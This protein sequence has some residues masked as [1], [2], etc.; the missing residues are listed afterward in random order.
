MKAFLRYPTLYL[1]CLFALLAKSPAKGQHVALTS[2]ETAFHLRNHN[3]A[4]LTF[5]NS[6]AGFQSLIVKSKEGRFAEL[7]VRGYGKMTEEGR[8]AL[9]VLKKLIEMPVGAKAEIR[10]TNLEVQTIKLSDYK[11]NLP[12]MPAQPPVSKQEDDPS[13]LPFHIDRALYAND[14]FYGKEPVRVIPLGELRGTGI[15][16]LEI[17]PF[18]Y[19]PI[20]GELRVITSIRCEIV[21]RKASAGP[22][23]DPELF[24]PW[25]ES[26]FGIL[27]NHETLSRELIT[28]MPATYIIVSHPSF[29]DAL[30]P[31]IEW[32]T[33]KGFRIVEAYTDDP[34][35]G[36]TTYSIKA[37]LQDFYNDPPEEYLPQTFV[38]FV[39]DV[40]QIP[41]F[42]GT[43]GSHVTD[44]YYCEYTGDVF[45]ECFYGRFSANDLEELQPQIDK[46]LEYEQYLMP[47]PSFLD[48]VVMVAG[49]DASHQLTWGNGQINYGTEY[50]FNAAHGI[51]SHTYLQ[52]EP[53]GG[54]YSGQI[55][56]NVS[57]GVAYANYTAHCS[58]SG[59]ANP[60]F[61]TSHISALTNAHKYPLMVGNCCSSLEFQ[62]TCFGEEVLRAPLKGAIGYIGGSNS[63]YWD[64]DFWW[65][66]GFEN[67]SANPVYNP[68][69]LGAYDRTFHDGAGLTTADWFVTQGQMPSAGNLA[70][71]Q[72]G[73]SRETY[74]WEIYHLMGDPSLMIY[75]SQPPDISVSYQ[76]LMPLATENFSVITQ[77]YACVAISKDGILHGAK[78]ANE[79]GVA[80]V[81]MDPITEPGTAD[82]VVTKQNGKPFMGTVE[83]ASPNGPYVLF[84]AVNI[85]DSQGNNNGLADYGEQMLLD[86]TLKN[87][88]SATAVDVS[89]VLSTDSPYIEINNASH[90]WS[91]ID[92]GQSVMQNGAFEITVAT[93]IPDQE[94]VIF[95]LE[96][97]DSSETWNSQFNIL[98][99]APELETG[100]LI[101]NDQANGNGNGRPDPGENIE[102]LV[103]VSNTG[104]SAISNVTASV[105]S[106]SAWINILSGVYEI[107][108]IEVNETEYAIFTV[109]IDEETPV[110]TTIEFTG[111][112]TDGT[113]STQATWV[114]NVGLIIEDFE[115]GSFNSF[116]WEFPGNAD[117]VIDNTTAFQG[118][119]SARSGAIAHNEESGMSIS[120]E[121]ASPGEIYFAVKI[122][123]EVNYDFLHFYI[124]GIETDSWSG[125]SDWTEV[126]YPVSSGTHTFSWS[127]E[128]D[129][130]VSSGTDCAWIDQVIFP[131]LN[132]EPVLH[133]SSLSIND[134]NSGNGN[135][136][137]DPGETVQA[138]IS[139][140]NTGI[141]AAINATGTLITNSEYLDLSATS[142]DFGTLANGTVAQA[143]FNINIHENA[144]AGATGDLNFLLVSGGLSAQES[145][146][147]PIG[148]TNTEDFE[149]GDFS[150]FAWQLSGNVNWQVSG[151][152]PFE[153]QFSAISG[154]ISDNQ[155]SSLSINIETG[156]D[157]EISFWQKVSSESGYDFLIFYID[158]YQ[159]DKWSGNTDW[160]LQT[161]TLAPGEHVLEWIYDKDFSVSS[162][163]DCAWLDLISLPYTLTPEEPVAAFMA[164]NTVIAPGESVQFY[165]ISTGIPE[166][167]SWTFEGGTP[168]FSDEENPLITY[169]VPGTFSVSLE[170]TNALGT[171]TKAIEGYIQAGGGSM[172]QALNIPA[173]WSGLSTC[174]IPENTQP[175]IMLQELMPDLVILQDM[176]GI[177]YPAMNINTLGNWNYKQ[178]YKVKME[179]AANITIPG[180]STVSH[181][182]ELD[183]G[184]NLI[185]VMVNCNALAT[186]VFGSA[187]SQITVVKDVAGTGVYWPEM[188]INTLQ[189]L[190]PGK[191]YLVH[192][193]SEITITFAN[194]NINNKGKPYIETGLSQGTFDI[195]PTPASHLFAI[196]NQALEDFDCSDGSYLTVRGNQDR[197][198]GATLAGSNVVTVFGDDALTG[199]PDGAAEGEVLNFFIEKPQTGI[200]QEIVPHFD[201]L[202]PSRGNYSAEGLS[203]ILRFTAENTG[204]DF[205]RIPQIYIYPNPATDQLFIHGATAGEIIRIVNL[206]GVEMLNTRVSE[207]KTSIVDLTRI[208][209]GIYF[210]TIRCEHNFYREKIS[211]N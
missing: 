110:G 191:A 131:P 30:Q 1:I 180:W 211:I 193:L 69:H 128:K 189:Y 44:L 70:V 137:A 85:D 39:G 12:V 188:N 94:E 21:F 8:P 208:P 29:A 201:H 158:G 13:L 133:I 185:P 153:G 162:F 43:A 58:T 138:I 166:S 190:L 6:L 181:Q 93:W 2:D 174:M 9:P 53:A 90:G 134:D 91:A 98:L 168:E 150:Q 160:A 84:E 111:A 31:F 26:I 24:S 19:N 205:S 28:G 157:S 125:T 179:N 121:V 204:T 151:S 4:G 207:N 141:S 35:V 64:E 18:E 7:M 159:M 161:Y 54:N 192:A 72:S 77:P 163:S 10:I 122:S 130:S 86:I 97:T 187:G 118:T 83:V 38:L 78:T 132:S 17:S 37:Y 152:E 79:I 176:T 82:I 92:P 147:I 50:Y 60:S 167:Y 186:D 76:A 80:D 175:G 123:S 113:Y 140:V 89:A 23:K 196:A 202:M 173:G 14:E 63:T 55:R 95:Q 99:N 22:E 47:D 194:C 106:G 183:P 195:S 135:G 210:V 66:V 171:S 199:F 46:T 67:I 197:L 129:G 184:W 156:S 170:V 42:S 100:M 120:L 101:F 40:A 45:P 203:R 52:P 103:P 169:S 87:L 112:A 49:A 27:I 209:H 108:G 117:W 148:Y 165:D 96:I 65:G 88:G 139:C 145:F 178:G 146:Y 164:D 81:V 182:L 206:H 136:I 68:D 114:A 62:T 5:E 143:E 109:E 177:L 198:Y 59:W 144:P 119:Y 107:T 34:A 57:D 56:Q 74:Y 15:F 71:S 3:R 154:D 127:Y 115:S 126:S 20:T 11:I 25:H 116:F 75:F 142:F 124:D 33:K 105:S 36:N 48:E 41:A 61:T 172:T 51:Y 102:I 200:R 155:I 73:S 32:K 104:H 149:T 16:R